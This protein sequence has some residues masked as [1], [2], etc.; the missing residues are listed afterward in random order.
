MRRAIHANAMNK[1]KTYYIG[2]ETRDI[3]AA[4]KCQIASVAVTWGF[5]SESILS[6]FHPDYV[7]REPEEL[8]GIIWG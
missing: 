5:N 2:D 4:Q 1:S 8:W 3:E 7:A 6:K